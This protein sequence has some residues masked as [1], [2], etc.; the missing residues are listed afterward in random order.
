[1][2]ADFGIFAY[3]TDTLFLNTTDAGDYGIIGFKFANLL[4]DT[5]LGFNDYLE[6]ELFDGLFVPKLTV[7]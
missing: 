2:P 1:M 5:I 6:P 4:G 3:F 7:V